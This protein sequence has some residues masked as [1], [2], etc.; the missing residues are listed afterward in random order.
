MRERSRAGVRAMLQAL[1]GCE[2]LARRPG[3]TF[4]AEARRVRWERR[5]G[6]PRYESEISTGMGHREDLRRCAP[7]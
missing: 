1:S 3:W 6:A 7:M 5:R 4:L 2:M